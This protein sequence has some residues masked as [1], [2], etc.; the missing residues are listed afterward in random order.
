MMN[1]ICTFRNML[2]I[3]NQRKRIK[4]QNQE[5][6][7]VI[8]GLRGHWAWGFKCKDN[9][10]PGTIFPLISGSGTFTILKENSIRKAII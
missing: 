3:L 10:R 1:D 7:S 2:E 9:R 8:Y 5:G 4:L 6:M